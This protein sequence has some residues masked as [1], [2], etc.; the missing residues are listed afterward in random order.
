[1]KR[2]SGTPIH[3]LEGI[4]YWVIE[5]PDGIYDFIN[6]EIRK[7][8]EVDAEFE[9]RDPRRDQWLN[10]LSNRRWTLEILKTSRIQLNP[11]IMKYSDMKRNYV[12]SKELAKRTAELRQGIETYAMVIW[13]LIVR[14]EDRVLVDGYCRYTTL[15]AMNIK[16]TY[17]YVGS[18]KPQ[19]T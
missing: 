9:R 17:A 19:S 8:W 11:A 6:T 14:M 4:T 13:P 10:T 15:K 7:E 16:R 18:L 2:F 5:D 3:R 1:M 12:F